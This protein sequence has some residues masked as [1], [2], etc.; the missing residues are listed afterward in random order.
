LRTVTLILLRSPNLPYNKKVVNR[1]LKLPKLK[2]YSKDDETVYI[3]ESKYYR[4]WVGGLPFAPH[5]YWNVVTDDDVIPV[6]T[7]G[8]K[9]EK[10]SQK[11]IKQYV[12]NVKEIRL[13]HVET[14]EEYDIAFQKY[15]KRMRESFR[16]E[17]S[18]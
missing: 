3:V 2:N 14:K 8:Y 1:S 13:I 15:M 12:S 6:M 5:M 16:D 11:Q 17:N 4:Q 18:I 7:H 9:N 10:S